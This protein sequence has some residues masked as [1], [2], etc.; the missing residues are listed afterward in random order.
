[1]NMKKSSNVLQYLLIYNVDIWELF[2]EQC[3]CFVAAIDN[4][5][6]SGVA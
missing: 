3:I 1:M 5:F 4:I 2:M 6:N